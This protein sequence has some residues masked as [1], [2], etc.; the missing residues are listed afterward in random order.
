MARKN[1]H[2]QDL[3]QRNFDSLKSYFSVS[4]ILSHD[5]IALP[6]QYIG[7]YSRRGTLGCYHISGAHREQVVF[8]TMRTYSPATCT[9]NVADFFFEV[10]SLLSVYYDTLDQ[11]QVIRQRSAH[12]QM[13]LLTES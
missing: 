11:L 2:N 6:P 9:K 8:D 12:L 3:L 10:A 5:R 13:N 1:K 7:A 4:P